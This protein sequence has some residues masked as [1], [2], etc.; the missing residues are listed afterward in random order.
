LCDYRYP[1]IVFRSTK[2]LF[3][4]IKLL[5]C[6]KFSF[7]KGGAG[8][9]SL[10]RRS[11]GREA[12]AMSGVGRVWAW[13]SKARTR[14]VLGFLGAGLAAVVGALWQLYLHRAPAP[15]PVQPQPQ[16]QATTAPPASINAA[17]AA[18]LQASQKR[19]LDAESAALDNVTRQIGAAGSP[20]S[21]ASGAHR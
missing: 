15:S 4:D 17:A 9:G 21:P 10:A 12:R 8:R 3:I 2:L 13:L 7:M 16:L 6:N 20:P 19:A 18:R 5:Q 11:I 14:N 1:H